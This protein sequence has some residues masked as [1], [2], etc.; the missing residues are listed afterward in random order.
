MEARVL[1]ITPWL[2]ARPAVAA[3]AEAL[4]DL[5]QRDAGYLRRYLPAM[6]AALGS[7]EEARAHFLRAADQAAR[8]ELLEWYLFASGVLCGA[9]RLKNIE[10]QDRK[11]S[12]AYFVSAD[13]Q[14]RGIATRS[15]RAVLGYWFEDLKMNRVELTCAVGNGPSVRL[16]ER[17]GFTREGLLRQAEW[18][19]EGFVDHYVF[20]LLRAE[21][22][23]SDAADRSVAFSEDRL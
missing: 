15:V 11:A 22:L 14:R 1:G 19:G 2:E 9:V 7:A 23:A 21:Y 13:H 16:A 5:I 4:A 18:L 3:D 8:D 10:T 20:G 17:L 12:V 6:V